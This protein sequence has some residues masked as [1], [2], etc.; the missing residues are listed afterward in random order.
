MPRMNGIELI[1]QIRSNSRLHSLPIIIMSYRDREEDRLQGLEA[2]ADYYLTK[3]S[4]QDET[5]VN[6]VMDLISQSG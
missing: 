2:G 1:Q 4:F 5:L 6:A 3:S